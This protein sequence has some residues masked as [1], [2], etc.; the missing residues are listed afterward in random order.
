MRGIVKNCCLYSRT[1]IQIIDKNFRF[2]LKLPK[3]LPNHQRCSTCTCFLYYYFCYVNHSKIT[4]VCSLFERSECKGTANFLSPQ[5]FSRLFF[6]KGQLFLI[7]LQYWLFFAT[8]WVENCIFGVIFPLFRTIERAARKSM[9][10]DGID[11][12]FSLNIT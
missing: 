9:D 10:C 7:Y 11:E 4:V 2:V 1:A 5:T 8:F 12:I 6:K 3:C